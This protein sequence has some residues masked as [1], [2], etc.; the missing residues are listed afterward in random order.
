VVV[1]GY[2][3]TKWGVIFG[4]RLIGGGYLAIERIGGG[5]EAAGWGVLCG[6]CFARSI[7]SAGVMR[8]RFGGTP[9][10]LKNSVAR[11]I[12]VCGGS[13]DHHNPLALTKIA[14][15]TQ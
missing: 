7:R 8:R 3:E 5:R 14:L 15:E 12:G 9:H 13:G 11:A 10:F 1:V 6:V 4:T 2:F